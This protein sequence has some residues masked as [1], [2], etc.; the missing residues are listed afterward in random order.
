VHRDLKP[1]NILVDA[2][3]EPKLLDFGIA[4]L[5]DPSSFDGMTALTGLAPG[6]MTPE[7][8]REVG[9]IRTRHAPAQVDDL[10]VEGLGPG[11]RQAQD[12]WRRLG[13]PAN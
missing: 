11:T 1:A 6:P 4:K 7:G 3:G 10:L 5:L 9:V 8:A 2:E 13:A 12:R